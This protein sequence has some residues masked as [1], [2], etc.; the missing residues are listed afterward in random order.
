MRGIFDGASLVYFSYIGFDAVATAAEEVR[1]R[2]APCPE[3]V[4]GHNYAFEALVY[5]GARGT[6]SN[7]VSSCN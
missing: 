7:A 4:Y 3:D 5:I 1:R 2:N 6:H